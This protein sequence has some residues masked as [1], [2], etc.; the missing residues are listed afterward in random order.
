MIT[1]NA[2][3]YRWSPT[4]VCATMS[5]HIFIKPHYPWQNGKVERPICTLATEWAYRPAYI[6]N[7][8]R[9]A[10]VAP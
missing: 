4:R 5:G 1:D 3:G 7:Q 10:A 9:T 6:S 8:Q 2:W